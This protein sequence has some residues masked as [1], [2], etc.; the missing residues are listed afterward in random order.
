MRAGCVT[1]KEANLIFPLQILRRVAKVFNHCFSE[2]TG[3]AQQTLRT[4]K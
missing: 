3:R 2:A 4:A 1:R